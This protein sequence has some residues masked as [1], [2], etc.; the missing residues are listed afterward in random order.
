MTQINLDELDHKII[1]LL[2][3]DAR[4]SNR[5]IA[6]DLG[7]TEGTIRARIK[8]LQSERLIQF[9]VVTDFRMAG[10]P[11]LV[12]MGIHAD[13]GRV[14]ALAAELSKIP[15]INCVVVLLGRY[16]L[17]VMGLFTSL[18]QVNELI[19]SSILPLKGVRNVDTSV[20][21]ENFKYDVRLARITPEVKPAAGKALPKAQAKTP[22]KGQPKV[23]VPAKVEAQA[24][25]GRR[26]APRAKR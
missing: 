5:Q 9:T 22:V 14:P 17:M 1:D 18:A 10:S 23:R 26:K 13:P 16:S 12:M 15:E 6:A 21:I 4:V 3:R 25:A 20:S 7:V 24:S 11:N 8:Y 19:R 2:G